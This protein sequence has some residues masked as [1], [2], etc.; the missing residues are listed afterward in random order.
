MSLE[1]RRIPNPARRAPRDVAVVGAGIVGLPTAWFLQEAGVQVTV[2]ELTMS[3]QPLR[4][5]TRDG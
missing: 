1:H 5:A 4:G 3:R 2:Y